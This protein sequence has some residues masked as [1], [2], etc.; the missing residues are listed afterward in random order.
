MKVQA[1]VQTK[2]SSQSAAR[3]SVPAPGGASL[4]AVAAGQREL[5]ADVGSQFAER[6]DGVLPGALRAGVEA[7]SGVSM[8]GVRVHYDSPLPARRG[9]WAHTRGTEIHVGPGQE[10]H[11]AHEAWHVVQQAQGRVRPTL[12]MKDGLAVSD[13]DGLERE[14]DVMGARAAELGRRAPPARATRSAAPASEPVAQMAWATRA[15]KISGG[16]RTMH[17]ENKTVSWGGATQG[18]YVNHTDDTNRPRA[19]LYETMGRPADATNLLNAFANAPVWDTGLSLVV[20]RPWTPA[21]IYKT[22][23]NTVTTK[24]KTAGDT[25]DQAK[26]QLSQDW[27]ALTN[28]WNGPAVQITLAAWE[29]REVETDEGSALEAAQ[30]S[31][32]YSTLRHLAADNPGVN[33]IDTELYSNHSSVWR[34]MG[35]SDMPIVDPNNM[36][37]REIAKLKDIEDEGRVYAKNSLVTF[38]YNLTTAGTSAVVTRILKGIYRCEMMLRDKIYL[39]GAPLYP[40]EPTTY[41]RPR[42][43]GSMTDAWNA[44]EGQKVGGSGQQLEG[45]K[46]ARAM[47]D[48]GGL[49]HVADHSIASDTSAGARNNDL[50]ALL[51]GWWNG[52][53]GDP[54]K[55]KADAIEAEI[56]KLD[57]SALRDGEYLGKVPGNLGKELTQDQF[58]E[59]TKLVKKYRKHAATESAKLLVDKLNEE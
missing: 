53:E 46:L 9:A 52:G 22:N 48:N 16:D 6:R 38:G 17:V 47:E 26:N 39:T 57:Q 59:V 34:K 27:T 28:N 7:L 42:A 55:V 8:A 33:E 15:Y 44:M 49:L 58:D 50:V 35:D 11:L 43:Q 54:E 18:Q 19:L 24:N 32:P 29:R 51:E 4:P 5:A 21:K 25:A 1:P 56:N 30:G 36:G 14:A 13:D 37:S 2:Q 41:Y 23:A 10:R 3:A 12:Q 31:V 20:N 40:S 45:A